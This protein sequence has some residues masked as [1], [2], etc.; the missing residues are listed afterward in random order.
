MYETASV[1]KT[2][3]LLDRMHSDIIHDI[4]EQLGKKNL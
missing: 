3:Y 4:S 2:Q 1:S